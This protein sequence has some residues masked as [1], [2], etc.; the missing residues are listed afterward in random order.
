MMASINLTH[1][2]VEYPL[3]QGRDFSF[4]N[5]ILESATGGYIKLG[6]RNRASICALQDICFSISEGERVGLL[7][8]NGSGKSTLLKVLA[9]VYTP[10]A[11]SSTVLG[12]VSNLLDVSAG[13]NLESTGLEN[14]YLRC[15]I[16]GIPRK[17]V[18]SKI[19]EIV[20]FAGLGD[21]INAPLHT[22]SSG[23]L[24][25]LAFASATSFSSDIVLMDEWLSVGDE[26]FKSKAESRLRKIVDESK[27][28]VLASHSKE[29]L[30]KVCTRGIHLEHGKIVA[31]GPIKE[32]AG[33]YFGKG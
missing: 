8:A 14:V 1:L 6:T 13:F 9:G 33:N 19:S 27:I 23:M 5:K 32:V 17:S 2:S 3:L 20:E 21:F 24:L 29:L 10:T 7:G 18:L 16:M 26:D 15:S 30:E 28:L 31:D 25:R 22:Y 4:R 11:G 12:S